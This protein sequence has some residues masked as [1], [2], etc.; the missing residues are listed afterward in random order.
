M[1][2]RVSGG[3]GGGHCGTERERGRGQNKR[4]GGR[5]HRDAGRGADDSSEA[6]RQRVSAF[7]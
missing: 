7:C 2:R 1:R 3:G 5:M 6:F 4:E